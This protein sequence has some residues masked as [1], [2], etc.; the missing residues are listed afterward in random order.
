MKKIDLLLIIIL[1]LSIVGLTGQAKEIDFATQDSLRFKL[2][3]SLNHNLR[4]N[5]ANIDKSI[6]FID[7]ITLSKTD[8]LSKGMST[9]LNVNMTVTDVL[10]N[11]I[12]VSVKEYTNVPAANFDPIIRLQAYIDMK[13]KT[14]LYE[15][16]FDDVESLPDTF[17]VNIRYYV[18]I[19]DSLQ[20]INVSIGKVTIAGDSFW[21]P[22][23]LNQD[24]NLQMTVKTIDK[25]MVSKS[26]TDLGF[27][28]SGYMRAFET[29]FT[30]SLEAPVDIS[31]R[32]E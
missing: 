6:F 18:T 11:G 22:R 5:A 4:I 14:K 2:L 17:K 29:K 23:N 30:D 21:Y 10:V 27:T 32:K 26:D 24:E 15:L 1:L 9:F 20:S 8:F 31:F 19:V 12:P 7:D 28:Q 25:I 13:G 3:P 16:M